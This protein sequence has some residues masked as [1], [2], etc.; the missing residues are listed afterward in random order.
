MVAQ[1]WTPDVLIGRGEKIIDCSARTLYRKFK[2]NEFDVLNLPMKG[3]R[4]PNGYQ[5]KRG[6][7]GF[8]RT[9]H[10]RKARYQNFEK[11]FGLLGGDTI[12]G[13]KHKSAVIRLV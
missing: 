1:G 3:K 4:K 2:N 5:E 12:V 6:K 8:R 7:Q 9:L 13:V 10:E 11:E